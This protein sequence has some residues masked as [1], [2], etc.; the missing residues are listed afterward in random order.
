MAEKKGKK[1]ISVNGSH[2]AQGNSSK[3]S[4]CFDSDI[5]NFKEIH[6]NIE[7]IHATMLLDRGM[8]KHGYEQR[9]HVRV[10]H[11]HSS[12]EIF[13]I[14]DG[15]L[16]V[17]L[18]DKILEL[19]K[20]SMII[21]PPKT[22]HSS[23]LKGDG[24]SRFCIFF[25]IEKNCLKTEHSL[26]DML[27]RIFSDEY[28]FFENALPFYEDIKNIAE[29]IA[30]NNHFNISFYFY[31]F[32]LA[33]IK[34]TDDCKASS[35]KELLTDSF[36]SRTYKIQR[37]ISSYY[38]EDISLEHIAKS[39]HLSTRQA[40]RIVNDLYGHTYRETIARTRVRAASEL[41]ATTSMPISEIAV[42]VGYSSQKGFYSAFK[43]YSGILPSEY[44]KAF[45][46]QTQK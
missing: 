27:S 44:R 13:Y 14:K 20:D 43:K 10:S 31:Q 26:Y 21:F 19:K 42:K 5:D 22:A 18:E 29:N 17:R 30:Y 11:F 46:K 15:S 6:I 2:M 23:M 1:H 33:L 35:Y 28:V 9:G 41:L 3:K 4:D 25:F 40:G 37:I 8:D 39:I 34:Y 38:M 12:Y 36:V 24:S 32:I 45:E 7:D 16:E